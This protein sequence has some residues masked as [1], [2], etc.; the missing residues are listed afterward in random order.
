LVRGAAPRGCRRGF[1]TPAR[2]GSGR[3]EVIEADPPMNDGWWPNPLVD[4]V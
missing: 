4:I 3:I 1:G 2:E